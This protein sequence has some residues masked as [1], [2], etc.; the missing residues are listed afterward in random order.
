VWLR[1]W[2]AELTRQVRRA[3]EEAFRD[4]RFFAFRRRRK[5]RFVA[6]RRELARVLRK[7][8]KPVVLVITRVDNDKHESMAAESIG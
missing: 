2:K 8:Q 7:S 4:Q 1:G 5:G 6:N 3:A